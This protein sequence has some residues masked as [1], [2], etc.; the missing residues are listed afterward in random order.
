MDVNS[1]LVGPELA[2]CNLLRS[3]QQSSG[4]SPHDSNAHC[5]D[6]QVGSGGSVLE[7]CLEGD[8]LDGHVLVHV[9]LSISVKDFLF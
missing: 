5:T 9:S 2:L 3:L 1:F 7:Q 6:S 4:V 8:S